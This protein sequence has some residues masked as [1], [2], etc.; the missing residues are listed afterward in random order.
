MPLFKKKAE[1]TSM[2]SDEHPRR[3]LQQLETTN[4][5]V[6]YSHT[7][8]SPRSPA[9]STAQLG[10]RSPGG[11]IPQSMLRTT[12]D[13]V[14]QAHFMSPHSHAALLLAS[15]A[16][17]AR[18]GSL[19]FLPPSP[20]APVF[21]PA[22]LSDTGAGWQ[23]SGGSAQDGIPVSLS[24]P[25]IDP[26]AR[27]CYGGPVARHDVGTLPNT[28]GCSRISPNSPRMSTPSVRPLRVRKAPPFPFPAEAVALHTLARVLRVETKKF[29]IT[30]FIDLEEGKF[31]ALV[32]AKEKDKLGQGIVSSGNA[33]R[34][35]HDPRHR[36]KSMWDGEEENETLTDCVRDKME[37]EDAGASRWKSERV[38]RSEKRKKDREMRMND[39]H[40]FGTHLEDLP[41]FALSPVIVG[42]Y[43]HEVP[44]VIAAA[45]E[46]LVS[47]R[48]SEPNFFNSRPDRKHLFNLVTRF[49]QFVTAN[50]SHGRLVSPPSLHNESTQNIY[51]LLITYLSAL[52]HTLVPRSLVDALW[53]WCV[54]PSV[55]RSQRARERR[56]NGDDP[57]DSEHEASD[58]DDETPNYADRLQRRERDFLDLP[59]FRVQIRIARHV[60]LL[61]SPRQF[62]LLVYLMTFIRAVVRLSGDSDVE[63]GDR[64]TNGV[65]L[66]DIARAFGG[67]ILGGKDWKRC[68]SIRQRDDLPTANGDRDRTSKEQKIMKWL[69]NHWGRI[70]SAYEADKSIG[71]KLGEGQRPRAASLPVKPV[72]SL[73]RP[74]RCSPS[75]PPSLLAKGTPLSQVSTPRM[76]YDSEKQGAPRGTADRAPSESGSLTSGST[77]SSS[78]WEELPIVSAHPVQSVRNKASWENLEA[79]KAVIY[80]APRSPAN[81]IETDILDYYSGDTRGHL[82]ETFESEVTAFNTEVDD[83]ISFPD[84]NG[85]GSGSHDRAEYFSDIHT[86][87]A[88]ASV[89]PWEPATEIGTLRNQLQQA[90]NERDQARQLV[91]VM[92]SVVGNGQL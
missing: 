73:V 74:E 44:S 6:A 65:A 64:T 89:P 80:E 81:G 49:D 70:A 72:G 25:Q 62:S 23:M 57:S 75:K 47:E 34:T 53:C 18:A 60:L 38:D 19:P 51:S 15:S 33:T 17:T 88:K 10:G 11:P 63:E 43:L 28:D 91:D 32:E 31:A 2:R 56:S 69:V 26:L 67:V 90:L 40:L 59:S 52:S 92:R 39:L 37:D 29:R 77:A 46:E 35:H 14:P 66:P 30:D 21:Y 41:D 76:Q 82:I 13:A 8:C 27:L 12:Y 16:N 87:A 50:A 54:S 61:L 71:E 24:L 58:D 85:N 84:S 42:G 86:C 5:R 83:E 45:I 20:S 55:T 4:T 68:G 9:L 22:A 3:N 48:L 7:P 1:Q 78:D 79:L 36:K